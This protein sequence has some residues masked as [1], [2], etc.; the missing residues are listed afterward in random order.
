MKNKYISQSGHHMSS[1]KSLQ[2][3][4][5]KEKEKKYLEADNKLTMSFYIQ[6]LK[7]DFNEHMQ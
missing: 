6:M 4:R 3:S 1:T 5:D 7:L 2:L